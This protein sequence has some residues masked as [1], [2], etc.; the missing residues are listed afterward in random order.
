MKETGI[1][2]GSWESFEIM[3]FRRRVRVHD[4]RDA[5]NIPF[6]GASCKCLMSLWRLY[7]VRVWPL[8]PGSKP[9]NIGRYYTTYLALSSA[10]S[11]A[12]SDD[13]DYQKLDTRTKKHIWCNGYWSTSYDSYSPEYLYITF[14][15]CQYRLGYLLMRYYWPVA[16]RKGVSDAFWSV[17]FSTPFGW[18]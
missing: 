13:D 11:W 14:C 16:A 17:V 15:Y 3:N 6:F 2:T 8:Q 4:G 1:S 18:A 5:P 7:L 12:K 9:I 10:Y